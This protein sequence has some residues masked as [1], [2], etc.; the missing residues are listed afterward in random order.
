MESPKILIVDD[1]PDFVEATKA[2]LESKAYQVLSASNGEEG[3]HKVR[4]EKPDLIILDVMMIDMDS[5]FNVCR[6]L[7]NDPQF[8]DIPILMLTGVRKWAGFDFM[9]EA[10]DERWLPADDYVTKPI[11]SR[12]LLKRVDNLLKSSP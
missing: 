9:E 12:Q 4:E 6:E 5:G 8:K 10:V 2:V 1:D 7:K 11:K 3:L